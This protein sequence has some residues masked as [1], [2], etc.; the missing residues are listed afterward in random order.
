MFTSIGFGLWAPVPNS[1]NS[2]S[3]EVGTKLFGGAALECTLSEEIFEL[4][5]RTIKTVLFPTYL[6][7]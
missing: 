2:N 6:A 5:D 3:F 1:S 4:Y 7:L